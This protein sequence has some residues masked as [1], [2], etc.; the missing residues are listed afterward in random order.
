MWAVVL[1]T[2]FPVCA[3]HFSC[4]AVL[5]PGTWG[6]EMETRLPGELA[7]ASREEVAGYLEEFDRMSPDVVPSEL[8]GVRGRVWHFDR[9]EPEGSQAVSAV[10]SV[11]R[12]YV[13]EPGARTYRELALP[14]DFLPGKAVWTR[15]A[16]G[17]QI[18]VERRRFWPLTAVGRL[19]RYFRS[20]LD[21]ELRPGQSIY[22]LPADGSGEP[23][24]LWPGH[25]LVVSADHR[26]VAFLRSGALG[27]GYYSLH[28]WD[29]AEGEVRTVLSLHEADPGS[30]R[31]FDF[32]FSVDGE[33]IEIKGAT[34]GFERRG[35]FETKAIRLIYWIDKDA[36]FDASE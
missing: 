22:M 30:G 36:L 18:A 5:G 19:G 15:G 24:W 20:W 1:A 35:P 14:D 29:V 34:G 27:S 28:L 16:N 13:S 4:V 12:V 11:V 31:S 3:M 2:V 26:R 32:R 33:A 21:P 23:E 25:D 6:A 8:P 7:K 17:S 9:L 10:D